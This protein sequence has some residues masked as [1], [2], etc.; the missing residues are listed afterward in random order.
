MASIVYNSSIYFIVLVKLTFIILSIIH[1]H[2]EKKHDLDMAANA[3]V[4]A[5]AVTYG[6]HPPNTLKES[7]SLMHVDDVPQLATW[8]SENLTVNTDKNTI[9]KTLNK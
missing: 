8:L 6:A 2:Y 3:G 4:D 1:L 5:V 9:S 7:P